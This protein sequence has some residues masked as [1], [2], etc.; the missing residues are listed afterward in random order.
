MHVHLS[1]NSF[2]VLCAFLAAITLL[3]LMSR[4][5][6]TKGGL[7]FTEPLPGNDSKDTHTD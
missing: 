3:L 4:C 6:A 5:V 7:H 2:V 1:N